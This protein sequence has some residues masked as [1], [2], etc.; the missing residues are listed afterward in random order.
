MEDSTSFK[1]HPRGKIIGIMAAMKPGTDC[2][3]FFGFLVQ[4]YSLLSPF[5]ITFSSFSSSSSILLLPSSSPFFFLFLLS[6]FL[7]PSYFLCLLC[8][9]SGVM[10]A[11]THHLTERVELAELKTVEIAGW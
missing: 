2:M 4:L 8:L 10:W 9:Y 3:V 5:F 7:P 6:S 1:A 11:D